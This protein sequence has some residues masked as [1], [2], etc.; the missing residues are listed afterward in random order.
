MPLLHSWWLHHY[1]HAFSNIYPIHSLVWL[2]LICHQNHRKYMIDSYKP[3][4]WLQDSSSLIMKSIVILPMSSILNVMP[5]HNIALSLSILNP[6]LTD[7]PQFP[8]LTYQLMD[9][10]FHSQRHDQ[11]L[12]GIQPYSINWNILISWCSPLNHPTVSIYSTH[13]H[14]LLFYPCLS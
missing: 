2:Y 3:M 6:I 7:S 8:P 13:T 14:T 10:I 9:S 5:P 12:P 1:H 4:L 11:Y